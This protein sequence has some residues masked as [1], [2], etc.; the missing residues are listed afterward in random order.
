MFA[1]YG[2][3]EDT[4]FPYAD[5]FVVD[6]P[7]NKFTLQGIQNATYE[8]PAEPGYNG[9]GALFDLLGRNTQLVKKY[10]I[11]H[12]YTGRIL[13]LLVDG[14]KPDEKLEFRD[15]VTGSQ[16]RINLIQQASGSGKGV[17]SSFHIELKVTSKDGSVGSYT[18]GLPNYRRSGVKRYRIRQVLL[19]PDEGSIIF[20]VEKEEADTSGSNVRYMIETVRVR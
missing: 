6:V 17:R 13:Y 5:L 14:E 15:F 10:G 9:E 20:V 18:V 16:Y 2:V 19:S 12:L 11:G 7:T 3:K 4:S 8:I 1:Q